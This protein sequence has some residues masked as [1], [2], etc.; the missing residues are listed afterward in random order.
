MNGYSGFR[1]AVWKTDID[2]SYQ[3]ALR[4]IQLHKESMFEL[5]GLSSRLYSLK[6]F[7]TLDSILN[8]LSLIKP[9]MGETSSRHIFSFE[10][11]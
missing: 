3:L 5:P 10:M 8:S 7:H 2:T 1:K 6:I 4:G 11:F 9:T